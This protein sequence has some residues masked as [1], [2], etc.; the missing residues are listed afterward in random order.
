MD[1]IHSVDAIDACE[2][3]L[4]GQRAYNIQHHILPSENAVASNMLERTVELREAYQEL[5]QKLHMYDYALERFFEII[6]STSAFWNP[7][8]ISKAR[9]D[10]KTL[11][12]VN[13]QIADKA[14]ELASLLEYRSELNNTSGF[15]SD[16]HYDVCA[17]IEAAAVHNSRYDS[18]VRE[19]LSQLSS[20]FDLKYW[21]SLSEFVCELALDAERSEVVATNPLTAVA[22]EAARPSLA[23][24]FKAL[25]AAIEN[26]SHHECGHLPDDLALSDNTIATIVNCALNL[27]ANDLVDSQYVKRFR[28]RERERSTR[29]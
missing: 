28:Q 17:V 11:V 7:A 9:A 24:F 20:R 4:K 27:R 14:A 25:F 22:T 21:P 6:L 29:G 1:A 2:N 10:Q 3:I 18:W 16:T 8:E 5:H 19:P 12:E 23:D 15:Y 13:E 26:E